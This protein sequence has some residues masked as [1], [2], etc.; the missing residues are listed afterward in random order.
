MSGKASRDKGKRGEREVVRMF[1]LHLDKDARRGWQSRRGTDEPDVVV[2][3][4]A[5][6]V[7][8]PAKYPVYLRKAYDQA[9]GCASYGRPV[10]FCRGD[11]D[12]WLVTMN[13]QLF[14]EMARA[15]EGQ[16]DEN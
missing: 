1:K 7:K 9:V 12:R 15:Y 4:F 16:R 6:E 8:R 11:N 13:A 3:G 5:V 10:L 14:F 2:D